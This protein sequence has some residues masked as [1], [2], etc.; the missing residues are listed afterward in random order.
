MYLQQVDSVFDLQ[1]TDTVRYGDV[2]HETEV[3][4]S[5]YNFDQ[6]HVQSLFTMYDLHEQEAKRLLAEGLVLPAYDQCMKTSHLF[7]VLDARGAISVTERA[8]YI[9]RVR[10]LARACAEGWLKQREAKGFPLLAR[11]ATPKVRAVR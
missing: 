11:G 7:N 8:T 6:A 5:I 4:F 1:W 2:H 3:Q 9:A 10:G